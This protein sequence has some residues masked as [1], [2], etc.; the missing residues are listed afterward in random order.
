ML[1]LNQNRIFLR[2]NW[3]RLAS[4]NYIVDPEILKKHIP[5]GTILE[6]YNSSYEK[7]TKL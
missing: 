7:I 1:K 3:L 4:A 6:A 2:A 5:K